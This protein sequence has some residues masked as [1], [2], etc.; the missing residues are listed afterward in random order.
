MARRGRSHSTELSK[1]R[2]VVFIVWGIAIILGLY[3]YAVYEGVVPEPYNLGFDQLG[4][5]A[6]L[7]AI[8]GG[9][10]LEADNG[11]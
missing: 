7:L 3:A 1:I 9:A 6:G 10:I 2:A 4:V 8:I 11:F 5:G